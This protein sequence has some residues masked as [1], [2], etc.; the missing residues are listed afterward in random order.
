MVDHGG[1]EISVVPQVLHKMCRQVAGKDLIRSLKMV[2]SSPSSPE[3]LSNSGKDDIE[4]SVDCYFVDF[5]GAGAKLSLLAAMCH[6]PDCGAH[7]VVAEFES[8]WRHLSCMFGN[9]DTIVS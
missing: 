7:G 1:S 2:V 9:A 8:P 3:A 5:R 6:L 4:K